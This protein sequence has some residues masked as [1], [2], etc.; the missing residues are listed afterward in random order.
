M[1]F[2]VVTSVIKD[3]IIVLHFPAKANKKRIGLSSLFSYLIFDPAYQDEK[4][5]V[6]Q[7]VGRA[8]D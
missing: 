6:E 2:C 8:Q 5:I 7:S 1:L 4:Q 3:V